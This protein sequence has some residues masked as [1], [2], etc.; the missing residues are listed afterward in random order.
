MAWALVSHTFFH[1]SYTF[2]ALFSRFHVLFVWYTFFLC[3]IYLFH[4]MYSSSVLFP[5]LFFCYIFIQKKNLELLADLQMNGACAGD[6]KKDTLCR[7]MPLLSW[8]SFLFVILFFFLLLVASDKL[9]SQ[10]RNMAR[11]EDEQVTQKVA[12]KN[13]ETI[14]IITIFWA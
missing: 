6:R 1:T 11:A 12:R 2:M 14:K 8:C 4:T 7:I 13:W 5:Q 10:E 3:L 9:W